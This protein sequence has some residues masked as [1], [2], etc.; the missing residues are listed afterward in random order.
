MSGRE[1][2]FLALVERYDHAAIA[3]A[4]RRGLEALGVE[5]PARLFG[6]ANWVCAHDRVAA[7]GYTR[8]EH[9]RGAIAAIFERNPAATIVLGGNSGA[10]VPTRAMA[11]RARGEAPEFRRRGALELARLFPGKVEVAPTDSDRLLDYELSIG[12][13]LTEEERRGTGEGLDP[14]KR[15]W[16][17]VRTSARLFDCE[18]LVFFPK[19]KSNV[20][21]HGITGAI[22]LQGIGFLLDEARMDGH[23]YHNHRRMVDL[24]EV[25]EPDLIVTDAIE[26]AL[27]GNQMTERGHRLGAVIVAQ[28]AVAHDACCARILGLHP[29]KVEHIRI[30]YE[31]GYGPI[32]ADEIEVL[33]DCHVGDLA[34]RVRHMGDTGF[35]PVTGFPA[36][37]KHETRRDFPIEVL[38]EP[39]WDVAGSHGI[40]LDWLYMTYDFPER[41]AA[42]AEWPAA[43]VVCGGF[44][45]AAPE[46]KND[47]VFLVGDRAI[48]AWQ[49]LGWPA[50]RFR[51]PRFLRKI[52]R[53]PAAIERF[54]RPD[55]RCGRAILF[56]GDPPTHR[57]LIVGFAL[58][59]RFRMRPPLFRLDLVF[60]SYV[61]GIAT[62]LGRRLR[63][64]GGVR[65][66]RAADIARLSARKA[67]RAGKL[68]E[69][70]SAS[71]PV[72]GSVA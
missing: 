71:R 28:N 50:R 61:K 36:K 32:F 29:E 54:R 8:P 10:G 25:A 19:L 13:P 68:P 1:K 5:I 26:I 52:V 33:G 4:V 69:T 72:S 30:A 38:G 39:P 51:I 12:D 48:E 17:V 35:I 11:R 53:G 47:L 20:L 34:A 14:R 31:R 56:A 45:G 18:G 49:R 9:L 23:N 59:T 62:W 7:H 70:L 65:R 6:K 60:D 2:V 24:L 66:V 67:A 27:G 63:N 40:V 16:R 37:F 21:A 3:A 58:A 41:R 22:K 42:M 64:R 55:G 15:Y 46:P 44:V 57:D 43:T